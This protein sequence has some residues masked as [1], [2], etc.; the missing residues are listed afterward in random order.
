MFSLT[1]FFT[2]L[3]NNRL[4]P[5]AGNWF[6]DHNEWPNPYTLIRR[7]LFLLSLQLLRNNKLIIRFAWV[8]FK[9]RKL[10]ECCNLERTKIIDT[11]RQPQKCRNSKDPRYLASLEKT[12][13]EN[14]INVANSTANVNRQPWEGLKLCYVS[15]AR[16]RWLLFLC[17]GK[18]G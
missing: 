4:T 16:N 18:F 12:I 8:T 3:F 10:R 6:A 5:C 1:V 17:R 14:L 11:R 2:I 7:F 9:C 15:H 13:R